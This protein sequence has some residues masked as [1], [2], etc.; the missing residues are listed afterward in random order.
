LANFN[1]GLKNENNFVLNRFIAFKWL[2]LVFCGN[3]ANRL[4]SALVNYPGL[5]LGR[6]GCNRKIKAET[7]RK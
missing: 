3:V 5:L 4:R 7:A 6:L 1:G 2:I